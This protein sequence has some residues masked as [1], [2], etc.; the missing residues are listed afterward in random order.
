M[1]SKL[2]LYASALAIFPIALMFGFFPK[3]AFE[4]FWGIDILQKEIL[5]VFRGIMGL[6]FGISLLWF[7][8]AQNKSIRI[9][10]LFALIFFS[11]GI[12]FGRVI[13]IFLDGIPHWLF[14]FFLA[15][16]LVLGAIGYLFLKKE[17]KAKS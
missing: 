3:L 13:S 8:G 9:P 15:A 11:F 5:H 12:A 2:F 6:Y 17:L 1:N 16:E 10:A 4:Y 7:W 14:L